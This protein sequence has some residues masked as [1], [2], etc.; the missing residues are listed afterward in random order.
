VKTLIIKVLNARPEEVSSVKLLLFLGFFLGIFLASYDVAAPAIFLNYFKDENVLAQ[1]F[2][3]SGFIGIISTYLYS[4]LQARI[5]YKILVIGFVTLMLI[6]TTSIWMLSAFREQNALIVF[7]GFVLALPFSYISLLIFWGFFGRVFDLKQA[8]RVIG[9]IDTGQLVASIISLFAIAFVLDRHWIRTLDLFLVSMIGVGGMLL[10]SIAIITSA[11]LHSRQKGSAESR[12]MSL[13]KLFTNKYTRLMTAFVIISLICVTFIDYSFLNVINDQWQTEAEKASFLA[14]FEATVVIFSFLFQT[15]VTDW[16]ITNYGLKTS[17]LINPFLAILLAAGTV[18]TGFL[19]G[20]STENGASIIWFFLAIAASKLFI[21]SLKDALDGP[22]FK[23]YFLP[24][25]SNIKFDVSTKIE[26]FITALGGFFAGGILI[27]MNQLNFSLIYI[28]IGVI[29]ILGLWFFITQ[30]M[31]TGYRSTL[32][33]ALAEGKSS[34]KKKPDE[35]D[36]DKEVIGEKEQLTYLKLLERTS[37][38]SFEERILKLAESDTGSIKHFADKKIASLDLHFEKNAQTSEGSK[39]LRELANKAADNADHG[40]VI[41]ISADRLYNL[42]KSYDK[43]DRILAAK[44]LRSL[45]NDSNIFVLLELLRDPSYPVRQQ[46]IITA[47][48]VRRKETWPLLIELLNN[49]TFTFEAS[50]ALIAAGEEVLPILDNAF[51]RSGQSQGV[52]LK[53]VHIM[54]VIAGKEATAML[55]HKIDFPDRKIVRQILISLSNTNY[56]ASAKE[57]LVLKDILNDEIGKALWNNSAKVELSEAEF[58]NPLQNALDEEITSNFEFIY[59]LLSIIYDPESI[60]LVKEN[61]ELG[62]T[63]GSAYAIE[64]LDIF[65]DKDL[66]PKLFPILDDISAKEKLDKL[67]IYFPRR[68]YEE[69]ETY[70]YLLNRESNNANRWTKACTLYAISQNDA[71]EIDDSIVA[72]MFNP[73][74]LLAELATWITYKSKPDQYKSVLRR[75]SAD[76]ETIKRIVQRVEKKL[77]LVFD[78]VLI[79][80]EM[81]EFNGFTGLLLSQ[82]VSQMKTIRLKANEEYYFNHDNQDIYILQSGKLTTTIG[83]LTLNNPQ[84]S[85]VMGAI[86]SEWEDSNMK[87]LARENSILLSISLNDMFDILANYQHLIKKFMGYVS[88]QYTQTE[89]ST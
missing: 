63:D 85:H 68:Q 24:I 43:G 84:D 14:N 49:K 52:M 50:S 17:L 76:A 6:T 22:S 65:L 15:F 75:M 34:K 18:I 48:K 40:E 64:L 8:K 47:R 10:S 21:D 12:T 25:N 26:G 30:R 81:P 9:G 80:R 23:L 51:Y 60:E 28:I 11:K 19:M 53:I 13:R 27:L 66:K 70:N 38:L 87:T 37:P 79:I 88:K 61:I 29:P 3:V 62:T 39:A 56:K 71:F 4:Y 55:W 33:L 2:L 20:F 57:A 73:D 42:A 54:V 44:L 82:M 86:F 69:K 31:H 1:A 67:Q 16:I 74:P 7:V 58:N 72:H 83:D 36:E 89:I 41:S 59:M 46:A 35:T 78:I 5:P 32:K 45:V 77:P